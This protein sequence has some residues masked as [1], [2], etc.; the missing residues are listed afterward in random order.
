[1]VRR[2]MIVNTGAIDTP[3]LAARQFI[4]LIFLFVRL[5]PID[6]CILIQASILGFSFISRGIEIAMSFK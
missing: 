3:R 6:V 1:V 5:H 4:A 2:V